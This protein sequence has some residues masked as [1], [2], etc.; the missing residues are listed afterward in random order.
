MLNPN[1]TA[2]SDCEEVKDFLK[3]CL[4]KGKDNRA[5][6]AFKLPKENGMNGASGVQSNSILTKNES[7]VESIDPGHCLGML[8]W[9]HRGASRSKTA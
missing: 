4:E 6:W 1:R 9:L 5:Y 7:K 3:D 2:R 8:R